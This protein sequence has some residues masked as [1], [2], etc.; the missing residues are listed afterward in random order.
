MSA[1]FDRPAGDVVELEVVGDETGHLLDVVL[2]EGFDQKLRDGARRVVRVARL[3]AAPR[4]E[5]DECTGHGRERHGGETTESISSHTNPLPAQRVPEKGR[6]VARGS[7]YRSARPAV[8]P[9]RGW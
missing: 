3:I 9:L 4:V 8:N 5:R 2:V 7:E 1:D 6:D